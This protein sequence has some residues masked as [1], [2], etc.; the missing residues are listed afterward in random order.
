MYNEACENLQKVFRSKK[1]G[2]SNNEY[3]DDDGSKTEC[4]RKIVERWR[5]INA[6]NNWLDSCCVV[7]ALF[8][9]VY[10]KC[11]KKIYTLFEVERQVK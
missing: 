9:L 6:A 7:I 10:E 11:G 2:K 5:E 3:P 8:V 4:M 1:N